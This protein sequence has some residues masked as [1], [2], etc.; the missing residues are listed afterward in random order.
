MERNGVLFASMIV[1]SCGFAVSVF[2]QIEPVAMVTERIAANDAFD[3]T[4]EISFNFKDAPFDQVL[5]YFQ[6]EAGVPIIPEAPVPAGAMT[7]I[8]AKAYDFNEALTIFNKFLNPHG[9]VLM[10]EGD[11]LY[12]KSLAGAVRTAQEVYE[13]SVPPGVSPEKIVTVAIPLEFTPANVVAEKVKPFVGEYGNVTSVENQN[14]LIV[15]E[16]VAQCDRIKEIVTL[17]DRKL[18]DSEIRLFPLQ[19]GK[20]DEI[21]N[22]LKQLL[23]VRQETIVID[24]N[25][26]RT[27]VDDVN[28]EGVNFYADART[29]SILAVG[30]KARVDTIEE[31]IRMLD[32][33]DGMSGEQQLRTFRLEQIEPAVAITHRQ[34]LFQA[35][36]AQRKP[37][38]IPLPATNSVMVIGSLSHLATA[39]S[40]IEELDPMEAVE[41]VEREA[42]IIRL[43]HITPTVVQQTI[44][45]LLT[46][47]QKQAITHVSTPDG[48]AI[49]VAGPPSDLDAF[50]SLVDGLDVAP[51]QDKEVRVVEL[52]TDD[53]VALLERARALYDA[54]DPKA[55]VST[56]LD[57]ES[58][59]LTLIGPREGISAFEQAIRT[60]GEFD[61]IERV[62]RTYT[63]THVRASQLG[64]HLARL[65]EPLLRPDD[66]TPFVTPEFEA[67]DELDQLIVRAEPGQ[68]GVLEELL[69]RL[70]VESAGDWE[71]S[72]VPVR[73]GDP[74]AIVARA[75][76]IYEARTASLD[77]RD[78]GPVD[79]QIDEGTGHLI[80]SARSGGMRAFQE[81]LQ[82][83]QQLV[84]PPRTTRMLDL[85][86]VQAG[87]IL[88]DLRAFLDGADPIDPVRAVEPPKITVIERTNSFMITAEAAQH[89]LVADYVRRLDV[90]EPP[91]DL[92]S[93][94]LLQL[95]SSDAVQI[96]QMLNNHYSQRPS[97]ER[98]EKPVEVTADAG[99]NTLIV[100]AHDDLFENI[101][102][103]VDELNRQSEEDGPERE[104]ILF[105]L[106]VAKAQ[107]VATAM[108]KLY[109]VPP[110]PLDSRGRPMPWLQEDK[111]VTVS[112]EPNS[113]ALII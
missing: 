35:V 8:S 25:G 93:L 13:D 77:P 61:T 101:R 18:V 78:A 51:E 43:E 44:P 97:A 90:V 104:T 84:P 37:T 28:L 46:A 4:A 38:M 29:N 72:I 89:Q 60:A 57:G 106:K 64:Q 109:P 21:Q 87:D 58:R 76:T 108:D 52:K 10:L 26:A 41:R 16:T 113:N 31:L 82:Q 85:E 33:P 110:L 96:A 1:A 23:Q 86:H 94:R 12:L 111:E 83:A 65:A 69:T 27:K 66:G 30:P 15:V 54:T 88:P 50:E 11:Y 39:Q 20:A 75:R 59:K 5:N 68:F 19:H 73:M 14:L 79:V 55:E 107:D 42:R 36:P 56:T 112:A 71:F 95:K 9:V 32:T 7:F 22:A 98:T 81:A 67:V 53:P 100:A 91:E 45:P 105:T 62:K 63:T 70:D 92:P 3:P 48:R 40:L 80:I 74:E 17:I 6:R 103:Y 2:S 49:V 102:T 99:T 47:R 24:K 34:S